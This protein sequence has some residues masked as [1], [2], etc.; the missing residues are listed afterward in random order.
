MHMS[1]VCFMLFLCMVVN[2]SCEV[3]VIL[4]NIQLLY[5]CIHSLISL[6]IDSTLLFFLYV[7][8]SCIPRIY[9]YKLS[10]PNA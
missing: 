2:L 10:K 5:T 6:I 4:F 8:V 1:D 3:G 7:L 9:M